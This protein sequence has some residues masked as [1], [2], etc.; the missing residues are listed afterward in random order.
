M[1]S[2]PKIGRGVWE[3]ARAKKAEIDAKIEEKHLDLT[4]EIAGEFLL[5]YMPDD[6][7]R[8]IREASETFNVPLWHMLLGY[9]MRCYDSMLTFSP[10]ILS[11]WEG[12]GRP[13]AAR[14]CHNCEM[15]FESRFQDARFCCNNC[16][17]RKTD[18]KGHTDK[19][20]AIEYQKAKVNGG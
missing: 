8:L 20:P 3:E 9:T 15:M 7:Q 10:Y 5:S 1:A 13:N 17:F 14:K 12:G 2:G 11:S 19:C 16:F 18:E 6:A 4:P